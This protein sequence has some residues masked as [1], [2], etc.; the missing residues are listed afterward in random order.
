M[1]EFYYDFMH[2]ACLLP[3][4]KAYLQFI[5]TKLTAIVEECNKKWG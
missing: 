4:I 2:N 3:V 5:V 1:S